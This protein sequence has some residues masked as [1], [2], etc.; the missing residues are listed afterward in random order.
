MWQSKQI[1]LNEGNPG[2]CDSCRVILHLMI[3]I[4]RI[5][6]KKVYLSIASSLCIHVNSPIN[7]AVQCQHERCVSILLE[8]HADPNLV[9]I[10]GNTAL[11]LAANIPSISIAGLLL[12]YEADINAQ[13]K[14]TLPDMFSYYSTVS[15]P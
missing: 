15:Q 9:D 12:E 8:N 2:W 10:N 7:Q 5:V 3:N 11:H 6:C 4:V 13:N 1:R 14:V